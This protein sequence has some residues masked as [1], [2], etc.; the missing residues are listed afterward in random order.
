MGSQAIELFCP[1]TPTT[2][3]YVFC[4]CCPLSCVRNGVLRIRMGGWSLVRDVRGSTL[5]SKYR[6]VLCIRKGEL[7][8]GIS[9]GD[10]DPSLAQTC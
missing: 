9:F 7:I 5:A 3:C 2:L 8:P 4:P 1:S 6:A 10:H